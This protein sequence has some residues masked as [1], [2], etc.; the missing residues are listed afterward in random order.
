M[1]IHR[2]ISQGSLE[3]NALRAGKVTAS[4][5][6]RL[7]TPLGKVKTGDGPRS[8]LCEKV[9]E[10]WKGMTLPSAAFW[11][12]D[13]GQFLEEY[14]R[15]AFAF[16]TGL[17]VEQVGF[18]ESE[19]GSM[20]ASPDGLIIGQECGLEIKSPHAQTHVRYLLDGVLPP[21]YV[22]QVQGSLYVSGY[23]KWYFFSFRREFPPF[24]LIVEPDP[25]IQ[26][27]IGEA[28]KAF[29]ALKETSLAYLTKLNG[30]VRPP[31]MR[32]TQDAPETP[33]GDESDLIL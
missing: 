4:E 20:G 10:A 21:D 11:D 31:P 25:K 13:Q 30:G 2:N 9:A 28:V 12:A 7:V 29:N 33:T 26:E 17:E 32:L 27:A 23:P 5:L 6:D 18:I 14:A 24:I 19:D 16:E 15:P 1:K 8:Y 22:L 3:W